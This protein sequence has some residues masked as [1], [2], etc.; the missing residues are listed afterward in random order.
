AHPEIRPRLQAAGGAAGAVLAASHPELGERYLHVEG[1][2]TLLFTENET[3]SARLVGVPNP[4]PYVKD[5]INDHV[6]RGLPS[7]NPERTGT[8]A[9]A[10]FTLTVDAGRSRT[11]R[12]RLTDAAPDD[13]RAAFGDFDAVM[14]DRRREADEFYATVIPKTLDPD[15]ASLMRQ[16][17]AG[18]LWSKQ[19]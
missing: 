11:V 15:A 8:K 10:H 1:A 16:A 7:V 12:V 3:N 19:F 5:G 6:V 13:A 17:L 4:T 14:R 9:A 18:M 2:A